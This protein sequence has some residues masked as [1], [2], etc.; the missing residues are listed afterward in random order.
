MSNWRNEKYKINLWLKNFPRKNKGSRHPELAVTDIYQTPGRLFVRVTVGKVLIVCQ[1]ICIIY[2]IEFHLKNSI[3]SFI[4]VIDWSWNARYIQNSLVNNCINHEIGKSPFL[5]LKL[6]KKQYANSISV[7]NVRKCKYLWW[8]NSHRKS[9]YCETFIS[10]SNLY[11]NGEKHKPKKIYFHHSW[12]SA[13]V[14]VYEEQ[15]IHIG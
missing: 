15:Y 4:Y 6:K 5:P 12:G 1:T 3:L 2:E 10:P 9:W 7:D 14:S 11:E 8:K 13:H